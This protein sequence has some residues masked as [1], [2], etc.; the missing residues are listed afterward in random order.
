MY[1]NLAA[2]TDSANVIATSQ[3]ALPEDTCTAVY[4]TAGYEQSVQN[5]GQVSLQ[6]DNVFGDDGGVHELGT[7]TGSVD[8]GLTVAL[9]VGVAAR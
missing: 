7:V 5:L 2:A 4:A 9:T 8:E 1:P 3:I 6:T